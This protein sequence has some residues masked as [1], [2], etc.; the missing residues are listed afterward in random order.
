MTAPR[1]R[2][3]H[4]AAEHQDT[5]RRTTGQR[6]SARQGQHHRSTTPR[7][8]R[9]QQRT[10]R[11][12][13]QHHTTPAS[14]HR[15]TT[16]TAAP[17]HTRR[18]KTHKSAPHRT[19]SKKRRE[20]KGK[21]TEKE[22]TRNQGNKKRGGGAQRSKAP[23]KQETPETTGRGGGQKK[24]ERGGR[25]G[26]TRRQG[27]GHPRPENTQSKR[28]RSAQRG[29]R[30]KISGQGRR[31]RRQGPRHPGPENTQIRTQRGRNEGEK[32]KRK[33]KKPNNNHK[34]GNPSPEGAEQA[35]SEPGGAKRKVRR[36]KTCP[37]G[38]PAPPGQARH[39][40]AHTRGTR[41]WRPP[42]R[43][44]RCRRPHKPAPVHRPSPLSQDGRYGKPD[45]SVTGSTHASPPQRTR[46][47]TE[48]GGTRQGQP[49]RGA[50]NGY[51]AERAQRPC[52]GRGQRQAQ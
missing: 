47:K 51:D 31:T 24:K 12:N 13:S 21:K 16:G 43:N 44:G 7:P 27:P 20:K 2:T 14:A 8:T 23:G 52:R 45:A 50:P 48:P 5:P 49:H 28:Q 25:G 40:H 29:G 42:T 22:K 36:T 38:R 19:T 26:A 34:R 9:R 11:P 15:A 35:K 17:R 33:K 37:G 46:P 18:P 30:K 32:G 6:V 10:A 41:A 3:Q 1:N 39:A 4:S